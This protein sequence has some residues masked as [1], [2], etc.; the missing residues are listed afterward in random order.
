MIGSENSAP[1]IPRENALRDYR[2]VCR[3][4]Q[5]SILG[6]A[7]V[8]AGKAKFG[9]F[10]DGKEV[11][12]LAMAAAFRKGDFRAGYYRDQT[13]MFAKGMLTVEAFFA[14]LYAHADLEAEPASAGRAMTGHFGTRLLNDDG[15][16][17]DL[18]AEH[19]SSSDISPTGAQMPR[20]VGLAY[21][22]VLYRNL[23]ALREFSRGFSN[24]GNEI[25][26]GTIGN[27]SC[28]EGLF[29]ESI[30]AAGVLQAPLVLSIW[31]DGYGISVPNQFQMTK[32]DI[33]RVLEGFQRRAGEQ[34]GIDIYSVRG[35]DYPRLCEIYLEAADKARRNHTPAVIHVTELTQPFGH[36]TSGS[37]QRYKTAERL[38]WEKD[39]DCLLKMRTWILAQS[40]ASVDELDRLEEEEK[41]GVIA[42]RDRAWDAFR[43]EIDR[44]RTD[45][46]AIPA[47]TAPSPDAEEEIGRIRGR[48]AEAPHPFRRELLAAAEEILLELR[49]TD[50]PVRRRIIKWK[51]R[52]LQA[53]SGRYSSDLYCENGRSALAVPE[54][55]AVYSPDAPTVGGYDMLNSYFD[56]AFARFPRLVAMGEDVGQL[57]GVN[58]GFANLQNKYGA[59]RVTDTGIR[60]ATILGQAIGMAMRGLKPIAEIQYLDYILYALQIMSDDLAT[61]RWRTRGGQMAPLVIRTRGHRLEGIWHSGSQMAGL[62]H[63]LRGVYVC[64]PR[65]CTQ[66]AGFYNTLLLSDDP[67][68]VVEVLNGYRRKERVPD[69]LAEF[70]IPLGVPEVIREG[71]D[72]TV[73]TY[74]ACCLIALEAAA[75]L[76]RA[77]IEI[78]VVDVRTLLPFDRHG[79]LLESLKKTGRILFVDEDVPGGASAY[80]LQQVL[81]KQ[82]G[83]RWLDSPPRT[84]T[85]TEHRPAYGSDGDYFSKPNRETIFEAV[86]G[87]MHEADPIRFPLFYR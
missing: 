34:S 14:Q 45:L 8:F 15:S 12:Q 85:G 17:K 55:P 3:S 59:L 74:G 62:I 87:M 50:T 51:G 39:N 52:V 27:A 66:A 60:E 10:G 25:A 82:G 70:T 56:A 53:C 75:L 73:A 83:F 9:I 57:G 23:E 2:I 72:V 21:A 22:S 18:L 79:M 35:W 63:L 48:I 4:R 43:E 28:A 76:A 61:M 65:D 33:S 32:G 5:A 81:E 38:Q 6:R 80:M 31:D 54:I 68:I 16:W 49:E 64:V 37:H 24:N 19:N 11:P 42:A 13:F 58:Q 47:E 40:L 7:E 84:V 71:T 26:F 20:L 30:N 67:G 1:Q 86:Y 69:N 41:T 36:S 29:W 44:E 77:G 78:E 46:L